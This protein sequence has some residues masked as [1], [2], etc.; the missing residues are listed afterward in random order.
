[1]AENS[2]HTKPAVG[3]YT[4]TCC[5]GCQFAMLFIKDIMALLENFEIP[6]FNLLKEKNS[7]VDL[8]LAFVE[9]AITTTTE[10]QDLKEI[11]KRS[12]FVVAMGACAC[13]GGVPAMRNF[14]ESSALRKYVY[15]KAQHP[16]AVS[17][18]GID[19]HIEVDY[20]MRGCPIIKSEFVEFM[21]SFL[22]GTIMEPYK[23]S[24]CTQCPRGPKC[25]LRSKVE[26]L[27]AVTHGGCGALCPSD[28]IPC[29]LCRGPTEKMNVAK[30]I[31]LF[32][33]FGLEE[34]EIHNRLNMFENLETP[35]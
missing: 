9:G 27:G 12:K 16:E 14:V 6:Y 18:A 21:E 1:M 34:K 20:Y 35:Q 22:Q 15:H 8:D 26:C 17:V 23:G 11:R 2:E 28:N 32:E 31:K 25:F 24:V 19:K 33:K 10:I 30:E 13:Y 5:E 4:F 3:F 7:N 29:M